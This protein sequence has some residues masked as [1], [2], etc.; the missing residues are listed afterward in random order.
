MSAPS[1]FSPPA[2]KKSSIRDFQAKLVLTVLVI[3]FVWLLVEYVSLLYKGYQI[4]LKKQWFIEE[5]SRLVDQNQ[6]L[7]KRYEYYKT[8]YF[9]RKEAKRKLNKKEPGEKV[10]IITGESAQIKSEAGWEFQTDMVERWQEY[11]FGES[12]PDHNRS[13]V[14]REKDPLPK[15]SE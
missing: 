7:A 2:G 4:E 6:E 15:P 3:L 1:Q 13:Q 8:D 12:Q 11:L 14:G 10:I 9:F 5:N